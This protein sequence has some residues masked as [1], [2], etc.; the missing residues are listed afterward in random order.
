MLSSMDRSFRWRGLVLA[1]TIVLAAAAPGLAQTSQ[2]SDTSLRL[3]SLNPS[4][5]AI[6][7]RLGGGDALV[8]IDDYSARLL[9]EI[10]DRP[11]VG[12]LFDPSLEAVVGLRP[13]RVLIVAGIEQQSHAERLERLGLAVEVY[14]NEQLGEVLENIE[15]IGRLLGR[16]EAAA[17]R[18]REIL[19]MRAAVSEAVLGR[20]RPS[21]IA[22]VTRSPLYVVGGETFLDEMLEAVGAR[23]LGR[24]LA[25]GYPRGSIEWLIAARPEL[26]LDLTPDVE[27]AAD[28]WRRWPS[29]PAVVN[30]RVIEV[31]ASRISLPGPDLDR[32]LREL[33][34]A[35]QGPEIGPRI[36]QAMRAAAAARGRAQ[37]PG[38]A[39]D[40]NEEA[41]EK[42]GSIR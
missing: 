6:I 14:P 18:I 34:I 33:A 4:L 40:A 21:T 20:A 17:K 36:D 24:D 27:P 42:E 25:K 23:N 35:V 12:G 29:L 26:L 19:D 15:R 37:S 8:G 13:D 41:H 7:L 38:D 30:D 16:P 2:A 9:P 39:E 22:V 5:T 10:A 11:H 1:S 32:A 31:D 28:F 3:I